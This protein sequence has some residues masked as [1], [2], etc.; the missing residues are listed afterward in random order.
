MHRT[1]V[2][3]KKSTRCARNSRDSAIRTKLSSRSSR[4]TI[5]WLRKRLRKYNNRSACSRLRQVKSYNGLKWKWRHKSEKIKRY[6]GRK[7]LSKLGLMSK[8]RAKS[9][10]STNKPKLTR[11]WR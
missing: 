2:G 11:L 10:H 6:V 5:F 3:S 1:S 7:R 9:S 8:R 4:Q